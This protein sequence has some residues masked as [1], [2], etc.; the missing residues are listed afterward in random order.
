M[1]NINEKLSN[2]INNTPDT[3]NCVSNIKK[4]LEKEGFEEL[5]ENEI[6]NLKINGKYF[7]S[8]NDS[9]LIAFKMCKNDKN[10]GFNI[11]ASHT[12]SPSF[13]IKTNPDMYDNGYLKLNVNGYGGMINYSW[14]DRPLSIAGR[15]VVKENDTYKKVVVNIDKDLLLIP[16]Q[17]IHINREVNSKNDLNHQVD[18]LPIV[19]LSKETSLKDILVDYLKQNGETFDRI[20]D[21]DLYLYNRDRVITVGLEDEF[22]LGPRLDD[23]ASLIPSLYSFITAENEK[24]LNVFCAFNNEEIGSLT[25]QGADS[26]FLIDTLTKISEG[27]NFELLSALNNSII[28]S[29]DNAHALHPNAPGKSDPTNKVF[30]NK[31]VVI[32]HNIRYSTDSITSSIFKDICEKANIPYQDFECRSDMIC[33]GT[34]GVINQRHVSIDSLDI[35]LPQLAMHSANETIGSEDVKY[36]YNALLEFYQTSF[37]KETGM[38]KIKYQ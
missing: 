33:G 20:C 34:L 35:G 37:E 2:F 38:V 26:T 15:V 12:D 8:R 9:S 25:A 28:I 3:Y 18:M 5:Y 21:Y 29:V 14:L 24:S 17:A 13:S 30:L 19:S 6:W 36:M 11:T 1:E 31:G 32:K 23:L 16:S 10:V 27:A 4:I 7:V 22:I